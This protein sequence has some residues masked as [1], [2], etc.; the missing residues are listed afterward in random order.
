MPRGLFGRN[1]LMATY[2]KSVSSY[3]MIE[4]PVWTLEITAKPIPSTGKTGEP[5]LPRLP[6]NRTYPRHTKIDANDPKRTFFP[7]NRMTGREINI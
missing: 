7:S 4:A 5:I 6:R 3:R 1:V 2:S